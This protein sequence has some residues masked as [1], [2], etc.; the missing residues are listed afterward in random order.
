[1]NSVF[2]ATSE[3]NQ[4]ISSW[5]LSSVVQMGHMFDGATSFNQDI[6]SWNISNVSFY[7]VYVCK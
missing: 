5:N 3:F 4:D 1:M 6:A 2:I 7:Q